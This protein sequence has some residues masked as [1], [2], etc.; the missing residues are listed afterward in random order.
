MEL[1]QRKREHVVVLFVAGVLALNYPILAI[2]NRFLLPLGIPLLYLYIF[3]TWL[4]IIAVLA[5]V[6]ERGVA[7]E[8][9]GT[10]SEQ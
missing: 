10:S 8:P 2:F 9:R 6:M 4:A 3:L 1:D 5:I 7:P